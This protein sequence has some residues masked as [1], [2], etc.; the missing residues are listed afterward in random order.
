MTADRQ[1]S[2]EAGKSGGI[3]VSPLT[4]E[5]AEAAAAAAGVPAAM[6]HLNIFR[7]LL[8]HPPLAK[9]VGNLLVTLL[10]NAKLDMRLRELVILRLGWATGSDYEWTQHWRVAS[11]LGVSDQDMLGVR[12]WRAYAA[13]GAAER[14]VLAATDETLATGTI[15]PGTWE[16]CR[17]H[18][19]EVEALLELVVAI[20]NWRMISS[21]LR[22]LQIPL[23]DGIASWPPDG[24]GP[25]GF[26]A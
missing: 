12:D 11:G 13:F 20:G 23:E 24:A 14:A 17:V 18:V 7:V 26:V 15:S 8:H 9:A 22:S 2:G 21:L 10:W 19:G 16:E 4:I 25:P 5:A 3:R 6:A 1:S